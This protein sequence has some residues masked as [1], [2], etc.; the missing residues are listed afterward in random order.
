MASE[1]TARYAKTEK[2]RAARRRANARW[3][4]RNPEKVA[5]YHRRKK[6]K[7]AGVDPACITYAPERCEV[8]GEPGVICMDHCHT[9]L[10]F[11]GWLCRRCNLVLGQVNDSPDRLRKLAAY[12][13]R[14]IQ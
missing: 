14:G 4:E 13:E 10:A 3:R 9:T 8:C 12:L 2:G 11:R 1:A 7:I 5:L 6:A